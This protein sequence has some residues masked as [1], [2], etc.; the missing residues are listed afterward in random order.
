MTGHFLLD[1]MVLAASL[2][3][4]ILLTWL[5][6]TVLLTAE[7]RTWAIWLAGGGLLLGGAFFVSHAAIF[8]QSF[9]YTSW[10]TTF[11]WLLGWAAV[12]AVPFTWYLVTLWYAGYWDAP[13]SP[14]RRRQQP[15]LVLILLGAGLSALLLLA[16]PFRSYSLVSLFKLMGTPTVG[17]LPVLGLVYPCYIILC[18]TLSLD[19]LRRP[20]PSGRLM[21]D[22]A[23]RRARPWLVATSV[24]LLLV[25]LLVAW[26]VLW[27]TLNGRLR[28]LGEFPAMALTVARFDRLIVSLLALAILLLGQAVVSYEVFTGKA[29]P[30]RGL[31]RQWRSAVILAAGYGAAVGLS[32]TAHL[33]PVYSLL[34]TTILMTLFFALFSWRSYVERER[35]IEHLRP[36][37]ASPRLYDHLLTPSPS[38]V[39]GAD[40]AAPFHALCDAVLGARVAYLVALG[41]LAPLAGPALAYPG[42]ELPHT[43]PLAEIAARVSSPQTI[44]L[45]VDPAAY[46]GALWAVPLWS[47]RG[48]IGLLLLGEK[49]D[50]GLY[51]QEEMEVARASGERLI[52]TQASAEMARRLMALQRQWLAESQSLDRRARRVLHDEVLPRLHTAILALGSHAREPGGAAVGPLELLAGVHRQVSDLLR[53]MPAPIL[54]RITQLGLI[55]ALCQS[56][57]DELAGAFDQVVWQVDPSA[58]EEARSIPSRTAE[59][60]FYAAREAI[61]NA[62]QHGRGHDSA[63]P[64]HLRITVAW[65]QGLEIVIDDDGVGLAAAARPGGGSGQGLALHSTMMAIIGGSLAAESPPGAGTRIR[66]TLP[67]SAW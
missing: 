62:A 40:Q 14:L 55:G 16:S 38:A 49:R 59:V 37:V 10:G 61:R 42:G 4:A 8:G 58:E 9:T 22:L 64:L 24:L 25:S 46:G 54:P 56:V 23:R 60:L 39:P 65:H 30:R 29:L 41:P 32:L 13:R 5:G 53:E 3:N 63:R 1:W 50:G 18:I 35:Y 15:W 27:V 44:C 43:A 52:D 57:S 51:T 19:A 47:Q 11:W 6:S 7:R 31:L 33:R 48:L 45:P 66:L 17:Q 20:E 34:L 21:G 36:F 12:I 2:F 28:P 26:V 67:R